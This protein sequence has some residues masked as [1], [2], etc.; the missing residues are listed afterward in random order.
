MPVAPD[1]LELFETVIQLWDLR[2]DADKVLM[3]K[4]T[5]ESQTHAYATGQKDA[6]MECRNQLEFLRNA[7]L[8]GGEND[9]AV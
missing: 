8:D 5:A 1:V 6:R 2:I 7:V 4:A 3:E 9:A